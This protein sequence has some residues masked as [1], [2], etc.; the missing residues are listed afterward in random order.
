MRNLFLFI[1]RHYFY[2]LALL[3]EVIAFV[4]IVQYNQYPGAAIF[5]ISSE[6]NGSVKQAQQDVASYF[7]LRRTN[8]LLATEN[9]ILRTLSTNA[10]MLTDTGSFW[11][12]DTLYRQKYRYIPARVGGNSVNQRNN[13]M[14]IEKGSGSGIRKDMGVITSTGIA[15]IVV[16][17]SPNFSSVMS[18]LHSAT[19]ISAKLKKNNQ[20]GS[21]V[22]KGGSYSKANLLNIPVHLEI[23]KGDTVITSGFSHI[24]PEG[25]MIG[26]I[27]DFKYSEG[28]YYDI[29]I[30]LSVD[31]NNLSYVYV[32]ENLFR[33]EQEELIKMQST[34]IQAKP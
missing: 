21:I 12:N 15:G 6:I 27:Q 31:F 1:W 34:I 29:S 25:I 19:V 5:K 33:N 18:V 17:V 4:L 30:K 8:Q 26:T 22:W 28:D 2:F 3:L 24:F 13:F 16:G 23:Q 10:F 7:K 11:V 9:A 20:L 14:I 32:V